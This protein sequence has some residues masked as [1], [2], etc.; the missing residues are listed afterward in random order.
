M[1]GVDLEAFDRKTFERLKKAEANYFWFDVRRRW[2]H[3]VIK[4]NFKPGSRVLDVGCGTGNVSSY[5]S[6]RGYRV[7]GC[8]YSNDALDIAWEGFEKVQGDASSLPFE[9]GSFDVVGLF[10]V[11]EHMDDDSS[12]V[13]EAARVTRDGGAV[14]ITVPALASLWSNVDDLASH[15][16]RYDKA[17]FGRLMRDAGLDIATNKYIF[18][19]LY[20]PMRIAR[21]KKVDITDDYFG[22]DPLLNGLLKAVC[23]M[24]RYISRIIPMPFGTSLIAAGRKRGGN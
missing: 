13:K 23:N 22:I 16:R 8:E 10:D 15:K 1:K 24:E 5:L 11:I 20:L 3:D 21:R 6:K 9:D 2:I 7:T 14:V 4:R 18:A 17:S 12:V 19:S